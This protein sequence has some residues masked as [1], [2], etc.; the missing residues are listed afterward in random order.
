[1]K[2]PPLFYVSCFLFSFFCFS[3]LNGLAPFRASSRTNMNCNGR[4]R[5][6]RA[7]RSAAVFFFFFFFFF[8]FSLSDE[9]ATNRVRVCYL[10]SKC[11]G[12]KENNMISDSSR[13]CWRFFIDDSTLETMKRTVE[14]GLFR[15]VSIG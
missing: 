3:F 4:H 15:G 6:V 13:R 5:Y 8:F 10:P 9:E 7:R 11:E 2:S 12:I 1:M 14:N